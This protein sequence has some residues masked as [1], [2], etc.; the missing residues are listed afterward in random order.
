M[1]L[2]TPPD[3]DTLPPGAVPLPRDDDDE[4]DTRPYPRGPGGP[5]DEADKHEQTPA[6]TTAVAG[7]VSGDA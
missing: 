4:A 2:P 1:M 5:R 6:S 3:L 7:V